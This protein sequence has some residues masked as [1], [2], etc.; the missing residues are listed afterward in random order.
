MN[1]PSSQRVRKRQ[2]RTRAQLLSVAH[3]LMSKKGVDETTIQEIT[4]AADVGFGT[5][6]NYFSSKDD[7]ATQVLDCVINNLGLRND[8]VTK[9]TRATDP[10]Q[11]VATSVRLVVREMMTNPMWHWW[12]KQR[13]DLL[14][15]R[16]RAGFRRFGIRDI[17]RAMDAGAYRI[18]NDDVE[19]AW[20]FLS[21]LLAGGAKDI[22]DKYR[23]AEIEPFIAESVMRVMG[24]PL[25]RAALVVR[26]KL[27][28]YPKLEI[29][30]SFMA[31][32]T[33]PPKAAIIAA[34]RAKILV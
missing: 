19:A 2:L 25:E 22:I 12:V 31:E 23:P 8:L 5:F 24:V 9:T 4:D 26:K 10:V 11:V 34:S 27:P 30:F 29:D 18:I 20:S 13:T 7:L 16:M 28:V 21:W 32:P 15:E 1:R 14:V 6:Y 3:R 17:R 33:A